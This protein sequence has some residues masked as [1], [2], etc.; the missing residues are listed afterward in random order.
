MSNYAA[1]APKHDLFSSCSICR[2]LQSDFERAGKKHLVQT[3]ITFDSLRESVGKGCPICTVVRDGILQCHPE[4]QNW[5]PQRLIYWQKADE[6]ERT[7][8]GFGVFVLSKDIVFYTIRG[9]DEASLEYLTDYIL[10][11]S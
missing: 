2:Q 1:A 9:M 3:D 10:I 11:R 7:R 4:D 8:T 5:D 6:G